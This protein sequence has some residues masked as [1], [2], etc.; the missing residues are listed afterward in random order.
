MGLLSLGTPLHWNDSRL[1]AEHVRINGIIQL[2]NCF[3]AARDRKNDPFLW[4]DEV[5]YMMV[6]LDR[7][8]K[9]ARLAIDKD[10]ILK[11]LGEDG[12]SYEVAVSNNVVFH[13]EYGRYMIEAT[14]LQ[15]YD[16][17][18]LRDYEYVE[19][20]MKIRRQIATKELGEKDVL[21]LTLTS[22]PRMGVEIFT[23]PAAEPS[24]E[25]SKSL[26]LPDEIINR[27]FRFPTLTANIRRR[28][29]QKV[30]INIPLF[31]DE[32]T[33]ASG[34]D[35]SIPRRNLFPHHDE[36]PF[37]G[38]AKEG[39]IYMDS[40]GFGMGSSCLQVTM[41]APDMAHAR[42]LYDSLVNIAPLMLAVTA[43]APIFRGHLADQDVRWNVIAGAVD[44]RTPYERGEPPLKGHKERGNTLD[45]AELMRI[46]KS[47]YD[48]VDQYLGDLDSSG[49]GFSYFRK[50]YNDIESPKNGKV[51]DKLVSNGFDETLAGHFAHLFIR[52][53]IVIFTESIEQDNTVETDHFEN[54]QSTNWQTLRFKPPKQSAVPEK[55]DVPGWRV[56]LR[57]MEISLTDFENA[58]YANFSVLLSLAVLKYRPNFY[59]PISYAEANMKTAHRRNAIV[60]QK[61]HF[62]TNVWEAGQ[63]TVERLSLDEIFNGS[64]SFEGLLSLVKR[65]IKE[66]WGEARPPKLET[67]LKL[68]SFRASA[69]IPS[70]AQY[71]R[72][73]VLS[74]PDYK[75]DSIVSEQIN[76]DLVEMAAKLSTYD[77][78]LV[79]DF[80]GPELGQ[81]LI[82]NGY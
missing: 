59:L 79:A 24:G 67:Y 58:A 15:P 47:R 38:A 65:Y 19:E 39:H 14:P 51:Y 30:S 74:H 32:K 16:G 62:R 17:T 73:F 31:K 69:R 71:I 52:D 42:F 81:W 72:N 82:D 63:A 60:E 57:P 21:P 70:T 43:A 56:E 37:L 35:P 53:P 20:N 34:I 13:P 18:K 6:K 27:H 11:D 78:G 28:R 22:F 80:F 2:I 76:Y 41:Q 12:S 64:A 44:D 8:H 68:V 40:M 66:T 48:S 61:F 50:E 25:A 9:F 7:E 36:E 10:Y 26:F 1:Y 3:N 46:P 23:Y 29:D 5:E 75:K 4:G 77:H 45:T 33:V 54:I 55:H 49:S